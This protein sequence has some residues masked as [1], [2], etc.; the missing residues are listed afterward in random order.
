MK[1]ITKFSKIEKKQRITFYQKNFMKSKSSNFSRTLATKW[2]YK[3]IFRI[4][5]SRLFSKINDY[6]QCKILKQEK[7]IYI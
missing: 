1:E 7:D 4:F 3:E 5:P 6:I 2:M